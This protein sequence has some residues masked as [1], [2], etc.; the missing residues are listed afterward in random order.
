MFRAI[1][2]TTLRA[3]FVGDTLQSFSYSGPLFDSL[4]LGIV[5]QDAQGRIV[6][7][8][9]AAQ[10]VLGLTLDQLRGTTSIDP[11]WQAVR[12]DGTPFPGLE[13]PAMVALRTGQA[14]L[15]VVMGVFNPELDGQTWLS[16]CATPVRGEADER[17]LGVYTVF[18]DITDQKQTEALLRKSEERLRLALG[19]ARQ[20]WFD[21]NVQTG[22][23][24][25]GPEYSRLLGYE[26]SEFQSSLQHW[27][28][29][30]HPDDRDGLMATYRNALATGG[31]AELEYR[32][33]T[34]SGDWKWIRSTGAIV[35]TDS[36]G[37]PLRMTGIHKDITDRR[38]SET[39]LMESRRLLQTIIDT[40]PIR[41]FWKDRDLR[42]LG[43]NPAF[44]RDAGRRQPSEVIGKDDRQLG[45]AANAERY[46]ADDRSVIEAG[47][48][49]LAYEEP[50]TTPDGQTIWLRT[51]KVPLRNQ[52]GETIGVLGVY[53]DVT[54]RKQAELLVR[55]QHEFAGVVLEEPA[56]GTL[57]SAILDSALR[58]PGLDGGG[59]YWRQPDGAY[60]L[61]VHRGLSPAFIAHAGRLAVDSPEA[62]TIRLGKLQC[63]CSDSGDHCNNQSL[64]RQPAL[65]AEGVR[66]VVVLPILAE[67][68][69]VA[70]LNLVSHE[71]SKIPPHEVTALETLARQFAQA[72]ARSRV[73]EESA[74]RQQ[75]LA[76]IFNAIDDYLFVIAPDGRILHYNRAVSELLGHGEQLIGQ[77][78]AMIHPPEHRAEAESIIAAM[79]A[80]RQA[81]CPLPLLKADGSRVM[82]DTR[83]VPGHWNGQPAIIGV[84]RDITEQLRQEAALSEAKRFSDDLINGLPGIFFLLD[85]TQRIVRWNDRLAQVTGHS[86][87][88]LSRMTATD[89]F[90]GDDVARIASAV[91]D[92]IETGEVSV[93]ADICTAAGRSVPHIF[94]GR[95]TMIEGRPYLVGL[96]MDIAGRKVAE[97]A[98]REREAVFSAIVTHAV[99]GILLVDAE[100][101]EFAEFNDAACEGL[102]YTREEFSRLRLPD[103]QGSMTPQETWE[104]VKVAA[105]TPGG[106]RFENRHRH[107]D[108]HLL[109]RRVSNRPVRVRGRTYLAHV[110]HD[111]T[112]QN[113]AARTLAESALFLRETQAI[114]HVGGWKANPATDMLLWTD[115]VYR[116]VEHPLD[117]PPVGLEEGLQYYA[118]EFLPAIRKHLLAAWESGTPFT[119]ETEM[120]A[121]SGRRFWA[122]LRCVGRVDADG[123]TFLTGTFQDITERKRVA[124]E[125]ERHQQHLEDMVASRTA[126]LE[127]ANRRL[128]ISDKR[129]K[130]MF[131]MSQ[132]AG[133]LE[134]K[135]LLQRGI[136]EAVRLTESEIGYL[137]FVNEDQQ[138]IELY[139]WS[140]ATL[141]YCTAAHDKHYPVPQAGIWADSL[142]SRRPVLHNDYQGLPNRHGYPEGHA[143]LVRH[144]GVPIIEG[145][146]V[147]VLFGVG[148]KA[149]DYD[150]SD[151]HQLQLIGEDLWR[152]VMRRRAEAEL[153][154]AKDAA[155]QASRAKSSFL[156]NM[157]H[158]I[159][160]PMNAIMGFTHLALQDTTDPRQRGHLRKIGDA[161]AHLLQIINDILDFSKIEAGKLVLEETDFQVHQ[162]LE[163]VSLLVSERI[164]A[165][166]LEL[167]KFVVPELHGMLRGDPLRLGQ[168][169]LNF[170]SNA[171]KFTER[172]SV[173]LR[174]RLMAETAGRLLTRWEVT[175]TGIGI[176]REDQQRLFQAFVQADAAT[177][178]KYGGTGLGLTISARL[179]QLMGGQVGLDSEPGHGS[180]FWFTAV[181]ARSQ[182]AVP[183][184]EAESGQGASQANVQAALSARRG[185]RILLAEDNPVNQE[186]ALELLR[187]VGMH[188][189]VAQDGREALA[190]AQ[191]NAYDLILMDVQM[192]GMD[193]LAATAAIRRLPDRQ[194]LPIL[195]MTA[196][197]FD[198]DRRR[199]LAA[200]MNDHVG[201][202]VDPD[203]LFATLLKWL[204]DQATD[205]GYDGSDRAPETAP[206][207]PPVGAA[208]SLDDIPGLDPSVGLRSLRGR[209]GRYGALLKLFAASHADDMDR[210]QAHLSA[211][212]NEEAQ[213]LAHALK[214]AAGTLGVFRIQ[215]QAADLEQAILGNADHDRLREIAAVLGVELAAFSAAVD[216]VVGA[217]NEFGASARV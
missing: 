71:R 78:I 41:V 206:V 84:S 3:A 114:A 48:A 135:E 103:V 96:G 156:A 133:E 70:S 87:D 65:V 15:D 17:T 95:R 175:D 152:I 180:T 214:G 28:D 83:A 106:L 58:L 202:P 170:V 72:I 89:F 141:K 104:K 100:T 161:A 199:C 126:D 147:R 128:Q 160:T 11:R 119:F 191:S 194:T 162:V 29:N 111:V 38:R 55:I 169:L 145:D 57:F 97:V 8:N 54:E 73:A 189:D 210:V 213:R 207:V 204:P 5:F 198:E 76:G 172:G 173:T 77:P 118:P 200:G 166:G 74:H 165:Q 18:Q 171:V 129:L 43:C 86:F 151:A 63:S 4:P 183:P 90:A 42:Y 115:E 47:T 82:V 25:V 192:P 138:T 155:E 123:G 117:R 94:T 60:Q 153:A 211:N 16:I 1:P 45:W 182:T 2:I 24:V 80:G 85:D 32:R 127:A 124:T 30:V 37:R 216:R 131:D 36:A 102:G 209:V 20:G 99:E 31:P 177:T 157:S 56:Q 61:V 7:A 174:V 168:I 109:E 23:V 176:G 12:E 122:E 140:A 187:A 120:I 159:R 39:A 68:E 50:Q 164:A 52:A 105:A 143:H 196:N 79:V 9:P 217:G 144:L 112:E 154:A 185:V 27:L 53:D 212:E 49:K 69:A 197:A 205:P 167:I 13:H 203:V 14:V 130:A 34:K 201:K 88:T 10:R 19:S 101:M 215:A 142:R 33:R 137:H 181:L 107:K 148:N 132:A 179:A 44:A 190:L 66:A 110:W 64:V 149:E 158:E 195:A 146:K 59:L 22:E 26:P 121:A 178:R 163:R 62:E 186:V 35:E 113:R 150:D 188:V 208:T 67:G 51:S 93:E 134:E 116:L 46:R 75:N 92:G 136:E 40:A 184:P 193:G 21:L 91:R 98:L 6:A 125:L 81:S 108:G 139:T